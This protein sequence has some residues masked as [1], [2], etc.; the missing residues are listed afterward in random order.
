MAV[1]NLV[2][3]DTAPQLKLTLTDDTTLE[4]VNLTGAVVNLYVR[5]ANS[6]VLAFTRQA[7]IANP[8]TGICY[9][10]W[11]STDLVRAAGAYDAE[12]EIYWA[13]TGIRETIYDLLSLNIRDEIGPTPSGP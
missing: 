11:G 13:G 12:V 9:I 6:S 1:I 3:G 5:A 2:H 7:T 8:T 10:A 4:A